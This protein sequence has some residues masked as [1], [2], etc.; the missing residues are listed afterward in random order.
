MILDVDG[1]MTGPNPAQGGGFT[2]VN[3][4]TKQLVKRHLFWKHGFTNNDAELWA[5]AAGAQLCQAGGTIR[6]DSELMVKWWVPKGRCGARPDLNT[7]CKL[8]HD[9]IRDKSLSLIWVPR[10]ENLA[11]IHNDTNKFKDW[12]AKEQLKK[13]GS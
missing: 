4:D 12:Y 7:L 1:W 8:A 10:E 11:G 6:S 2:V 13:L 9:T 3:F 5:V